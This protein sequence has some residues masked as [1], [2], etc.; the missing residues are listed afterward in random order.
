MFLKWPIIW[1]LWQ[2]VSLTETLLGSLSLYLSLYLPFC[3]LPLSLLFTPSL[4]CS[5]FLTIS[6][7]FSLYLSLSPSSSL[8]VSDFLSIHLYFSF[9]GDAVIDVSHFI[10]R[11]P[12]IHRRREGIPRPCG[13]RMARLDGSWWSD[14]SIPGEPWQVRTFGSKRSAF[15]RYKQSPIVHFSAFSFSS[16]FASVTV[17]RMFSQTIFCRSTVYVFNSFDIFLFTYCIGC[18]MH[19]LTTFLVIGAKLLKI[20]IQTSTNPAAAHRE[21]SRLQ[22]NAH[23]K[24]YGRALELP[25]WFPSKSFCFENP[26]QLAVHWPLHSCHW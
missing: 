24:S 18:H 12:D 17:N 1:P 22:G 10:F 7:F 8:S 14:R 19:F 23:K 20:F 9:Y 16:D 3:L 2:I 13:D 25:R 4:S 26:Q 6:P 15:L 21:Y 5:L 11:S